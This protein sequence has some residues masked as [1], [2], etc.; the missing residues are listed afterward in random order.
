MEGVGSGQGTRLPLHS[1]EADQRP[2]HLF[3][4]L[5]SL[6]RVNAG[7]KESGTAAGR[8]PGSW[9]LVLVC[10]KLRQRSTATPTGARRQMEY[11][12]WMSSS[13]TSRVTPVH[14][15]AKH[16]PFVKDRS[17]RRVPHVRDGGMPGKILLPPSSRPQVFSFLLPHL[18]A[19]PLQSEPEETGLDVKPLLHREIK[20]HPSH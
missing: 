5:L 12:Q 1:T 3:K 11:G 8:Q 13:M 15:D 16:R 2:A 17:K 18:V 7:R 9:V 6:C 10:G 19:T 14:V 20:K 4:S